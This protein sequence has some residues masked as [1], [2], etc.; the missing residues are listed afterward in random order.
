M[1]KIEEKAKVG[2]PKLADSEL[3]KDSWCRI[4]SCLAIAFVMI[5][6][7]VGILTNRTPMEVVAFRQVGNAKASVATKKV[8]TVIGAKHVETKVLKPQDI[9][10]I[11]EE[12][13]KR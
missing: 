8:V 7:G 5:I 4:V 6:C 12:Q 1:A 3:V 9:N 2:R 10:K 13:Q 11:I